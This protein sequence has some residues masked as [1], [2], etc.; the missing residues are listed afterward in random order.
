MKGRR[1]VQEAELEAFALCRGPGNATMA[2]G[3]TM[4]DNMRD[5][6]GD[7][8]FI[9]DRGLAVGPVVW[10]PRIGIRVGTERPWRAWVQG[11]RAVSGAARPIS[12]PA[13]RRSAP[14]GHRSVSR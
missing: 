5:L 8:L 4:A 13:S 2:M 1:R 3:I 6:S 12:A 9:E 14:S 11:H 7:R 10:G